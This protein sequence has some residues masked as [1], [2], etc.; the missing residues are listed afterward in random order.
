MQ[1][2]AASAEGQRERVDRGKEWDK[3]F[4]LSLGVGTGRRG[5]EA[6]S[7]GGMQ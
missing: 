4:H 5:R 7:A 1:M 2:T 3:C 6:A